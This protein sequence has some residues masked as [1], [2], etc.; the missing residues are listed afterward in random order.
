MRCSSSDRRRRTRLLESAWCAFRGGNGSAEAAPCGSAERSR[1][2]DAGD[3]T[4]E[5]TAAADPPSTAAPV[6][7]VTQPPLCTR[8]QLETLAGGTFRRYSGRCL[9]SWTIP[10]PGAHAATAAALADRV[11]SIDGEPGSMGTVRIVTET[12]V[13]PD[14]WYMH[15]GRM[16]PGVVIESGEPT[17]C[18]HRGWE[19][20]SPIA[21]SAFTACS[22]VI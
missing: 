17:C 6:T 18:S 21:A 9:P 15:A 11:M 3:A 1:G 10:A 8:A 7:P 4:V 5:A 22:A 13:S 16:S 19:P 2:G 20:I 14:A 12:D